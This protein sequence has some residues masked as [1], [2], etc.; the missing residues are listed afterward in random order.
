MQHI[1]LYLPIL[2]YAQMYYEVNLW[3]YFQ[4]QDA[5]LIVF[6]E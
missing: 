5:L 4:A 1:F 6:Y 2:Y 3:L